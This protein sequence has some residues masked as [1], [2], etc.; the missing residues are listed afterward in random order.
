MV[1]GV[2]IFD[3]NETRRCTAL[4]TRGMFEIIRLWPVLILRHCDTFA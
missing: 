3:V 2:F 1:T 4:Q